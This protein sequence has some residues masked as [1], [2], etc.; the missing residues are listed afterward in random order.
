M[1]V[2]VPTWKFRTI[3]PNYLVPNKLIFLPCKHKSIVLTSNTLLKRI[4]FPSLVLLS[5]HIPPDSRCSALVL[6]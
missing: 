6:P 4:K 5:A 3:K 2:G 1:L